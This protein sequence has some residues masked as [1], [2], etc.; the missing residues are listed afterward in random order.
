MITLVREVMTRDPVCCTPDARL[1]QVARMMVEQDCG[2][3]PVVESER[4]RKLVG[5]VTDRDIVC[6]T[7]AEEKNPLEMT[8]ESCMSTSVV[9][10]AP[11]AS[12]KECCQQ[13]E[14]HQIRRI[15]VVDQSGSCCGLVAQADLAMKAPKEEAAE[16]V[17]EVS[18]PQ[19]TSR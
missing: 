16:V 14:Q 4:S 19:S 1:S 17:E 10:I 12:I 11:E 8:A 9:T 18:Q 6:R 7:V 5:V 2:A 3:I 13:M 15:A